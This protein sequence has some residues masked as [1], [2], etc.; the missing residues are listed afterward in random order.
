MR[1]G[2]TGT[3]D[4]GK[5][6]LARA[7]ASRLN[8]PLITNNPEDSLVVLG[9][10]TT[11]GTVHVVRRKLR[12]DYSTYQWDLLKRQINTEMRH[13]S[14]F[15][16]DNTTLE[17]YVHYMLNSP[18][19]IAFKEAYKNIALLEHFMN[20][21]DYVIYIPLD[22]SQNYIT[23][24]QELADYQY[25]VDKMISQF[26]D[27]GRNVLTVAGDSFDDWVEESLKW[28]LGDE[29]YIMPTPLVGDKED[30]CER[31]CHSACNKEHC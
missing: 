7:L 31:V 28:I 30:F 13:Q 10:I 15:V 22:V 1:I 29:Y 4:V 27:C 8:L 9:E 14:G 2:I 11:M 26:V 16:S 23:N 6:S 3:F 20:N 17:M 12:N 19:Y 24:D 25:K 18:D 21:Y 5:Q